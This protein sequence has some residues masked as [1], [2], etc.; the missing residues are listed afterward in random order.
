MNNYLTEFGGTPVKDNTEPSLSDIG[1]LAGIFDGEGSIVIN[2]RIK[3]HLTPYVG[4]H[5][6]NSDLLLLGKCQSL[7]KAI[8]GNPVK[9]YER[10]QYEN[11]LIKSTK[12]CYGIDLHK[13]KT[14]YKILNL[15]VNHLTA[16]KRKAELVLEYLS[17][18]LKERENPLFC[19]KLSSKT[20]KCISRMMSEWTGV[21]TK[22]ETPEKD[23]AIVRPL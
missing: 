12:P 14:V 1:W 7:I 15:I 18:R 23:E 4:L 8:T 17:I 13:Q 9:L 20:K 22:R 2:K 5:I 10:K 3:K 19:N 6:A 16:K 11:S 21:E